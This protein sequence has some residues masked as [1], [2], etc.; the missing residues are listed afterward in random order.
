MGV[1]VEE[2]ARAIRSEYGAQGNE[3]QFE[4]IAGVL[5]VLSR[6]DSLL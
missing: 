2:L 5:H 1:G 3:Y 6:M 4:V